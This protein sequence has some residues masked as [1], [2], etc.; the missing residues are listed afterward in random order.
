MCVRFQY[1]KLINQNLF[2]NIELKDLEI[3][4]YLT[5]N[6]KELLMSVKTIENTI[7]T[8]KREIDQQ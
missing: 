2:K 1:V 6:Q 5:E 8:L 4:E 7:A 3:C